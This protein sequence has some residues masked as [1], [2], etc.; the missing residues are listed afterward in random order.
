MENIPRDAQGNTLSGEALTQWLLNKYIQMQ[1]TRTAG[2]GDT[3]SSAPSGRLSAKD[4]GYFFPRYVKPGETSPTSDFI[5]ESGDT[6]FYTSVAAFCDRIQDLIVPH[7]PSLVK[8]QLVQCLKGEASTWY[9]Q[10][11][12]VTDK[13]AIRD[14]PSTNLVQFTTKVKQRFR[15]NRSDALDKFYGSIYNVR[16]AQAGKHLRDFVSSKIMQAKEAEIPSDQMVRLIHNM[17]DPT[18]QLSM[19]T[20]SDNTTFIEY[21]RH[22]EEKGDLFLKSYKRVSPYADSSFTPR[23]GYGVGMRNPVVPQNLPAVRGYVRPNSGN[24]NPNTNALA[25]GKQNQTLGPDG[26]LYAN[27]LNLSR[28]CRHCAANNR[29]AFHKDP[30]CPGLPGKPGFVP[31]APNKTIPVHFTD[32]AEV[33]DVE[34]AATPFTSWPDDQSMT[35]NYVYESVASY[36]MNAPQYAYDE[37]QSVNHSSVPEV[38]EPIEASPAQTALKRIKGTR[39]L[40][41]LATV[42]ADCDSKRLNLGD[43]AE[44]GNDGIDSVSVADDTYGIFKPKSISCRTCNEFFATRSSL[45]RHLRLVNHHKETAQ[46]TSN[47]AIEDTKPKPTE[48]IESK[49]IPSPGFGIQ[50]KNFD[51]AKIRTRFHIDDDENVSCLDTGTA[52]TSIDQRLVPAG[53]QIHDMASPITVSGLGGVK[54][55]S[56]QWVMLQLCVI[57]RTNQIVRLSPREFHIVEKLDCGILLGNDTCYPEQFVIDV[58]KQEA[59]IGSAKDQNGNAAVVPIEVIR[60]GNRDPLVEKIFVNQDCVIPPNK[61]CFLPTKGT[62]LLSAKTTYRFIPK[63]ISLGAEAIDAFYDTDSTGVLFRNRSNCVISLPKDSEVGLCVNVTEMHATQVQDDSTMC[64]M[65]LAEQGKDLH[66]CGIDQTSDVLLATTKESVA[67]TLTYRK[68]SDGLSPHKVNPTD[69]STKEKR[70]SNITGRP[71]GSEHV[72]VN[73]DKCSEEQQRLLRQIIEAHEALFGEKLGQVKEPEEEWLEIPLKEGASLKSPGVYK[74]SA[75]DKEEIDKTFDKLKAQGL[76]TPGKGPVGWPVFVV[77]KEGK[78]RVVVDLRGLNAAVIQDAYPLS[79]QDKIMSLLKDCE[80][81]T[82]IDIRSSFYQRLVKMFDRYKLSVV[83]H[84]GQEMFGVAVMGFCNLAAHCQR[85]YDKLFYLLPFVR[86]YID[87]ICI[88]SKSFEEHLLHLEK[89]FSLLENVGITLAPEKCFV[90]Y[91]SVELLGHVVDRLG[92]Y[93]N[94]QKVK[95]IKSVEFPAN[96]SQLENWIGI[97]GYYRHFC[98]NYARLNKPLQD[99]KTKLLKSAPAGKRARKEFCKRTPIEN[100]T[101]AQIESFNLVK[102]AICSEGVLIH[103]DSNSPLLYRVDASFENG[104]ACAVMQIPEHS[105]IEKSISI[106]N[107]RAQKYDRRLERPILFLSRDLTAAE[108]NYWPSELETQAVVWAIQKTRHLVEQNPEVIVFTDHEA[109]IAISK[110]KSLKTTSI[111]RQ[112]KK[113]IRASQFLSQY[114]HITVKHIPGETNVGPDRLSRLKKAEKL[115][116]AEEKMVNLRRQMY[117]DEDIDTDYLFQSTICYVES[118]LKGRISEGYLADPHYRNDF[119][120]YQKMMKEQRLSEPACELLKFGQ[121]EYHE[122]LDNKLSLIFLE[123]SVDNRLRLCLPK[124]VWKEIF[125]QAHDCQN[126]ANVDRACRLLRQNYYIKDMHKELKLYCESC[127]SCEV[128]SVKRHRAFG[129]LQPIRSPTTIWEVITLDFIVKLPLSEMLGFVYDSILTITDKFSKAIMLVPGKESWSSKTWADAFYRTV[130]K[131]WG[132]PQSMISDRGGQFISAFWKALFKKARCKLHLTTAY[133]AKSDG[134][135]ER[136]NQSVE[137][138]LRHLVNGSQSDWVDYLPFIEH[139]HNNLVNSSTGKSPNELMYGCN[140]R[141]SLDVSLRTPEVSVSAETF[142]KDRERLRLEASDALAFAQA[143]M[144]SHY[145]KSRKDIDLPI[146]SFVNIKYSKSLESG[147]SPRNVS[148]RKLFQQRGGRYKILEKVGNLAYKLDLRG[149]LPGTHPV[150]S[151]EHL[152]PCSPP[153]TYG[154]RQVGRQPVLVNDQEEWEIDEILAKAIRGSGRNRGIFYLIRWKGFDKSQDQWIPIVNL[155]NAR[156]KVIE[157]ENRRLL[158]PKDLSFEAK[159][160]RLRSDRSKSG[161]KVIETID[162]VEV[163]KDDDEIEESSS[164]EESD[165]ELREFTPSHFA[166]TDEASSKRK[167]EIRRVLSRPG[168]RGRRFPSGSQWG[169][170]YADVGRILFRNDKVKFSD[171]PIIIDIS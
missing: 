12:D 47:W 57:T 134:Q 153:D 170:Q 114:P 63:P 70:Y 156:Q 40:P 125:Y 74:A 48:I 3:S 162:E 15:V 163:P 152:E 37:E 88:F 117:D 38:E 43:D 155:G 54:N 73:S 55:M 32:P 139:N 171:S 166:M 103:H 42:D 104:F 65:G 85:F 120:R 93:T 22:C 77:W 81:I 19:M 119:I 21:R 108:H 84:R 17:I 33:T 128:N 50:F 80:W 27:P 168:I 75:R 52:L 34:D 144:K 138:A 105:R 76:L 141:S 164:D 35:A 72:S 24:R 107:I 58:A 106:E 127:P 122:D 143:R 142:A 101:E 90:G 23:K 26:R 97:T 8:Q 126:H 160:S 2:M 66:F 124:N 62:K 69:K 100:P 146:G 41:M 123:D 20:I 4:I 64:F 10:E 49:A 159:L 129:L 158:L 31:F 1:A 9:S 118:D 6:V 29:V 51:F 95:A 79:A 56:S 87:D 53:T 102:D 45:F 28:P 150:F 132:F 46:V 137:I 61:V 98:E 145:D 67:N 167:R 110:M 149:E 161:Q 11:L 14:D 165:I 89:V 154:R 94:P 96:L 148:S 30:D 91:H 44:I 109:I 157:Y 169:E 147:Y 25:T 83:S 68:F 16:D 99:L 7:G 39:S 78:G 111:D 113:L 151:I 133:H 121:F 135:S 140:N 131:S 82:I 36:N 86:C 60:S 130:W 13:M 115:S 112:N 5:V 71:F 92:L 136:T 59:R 116:P 18:F